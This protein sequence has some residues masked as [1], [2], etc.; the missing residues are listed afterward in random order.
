MEIGKKQQAS[1]SNIQ[2]PWSKYTPG[3][4][5]RHPNIWISERKLRSWLAGHLSC[6]T[7]TQ[8]CG[9]WTHPCSARFQLIQ[10]A[11]TLASS[12][13]STSSDLADFSSHL[14]ARILEVDWWPGRD[15]AKHQQRPPKRCLI[16]IPHPRKKP[17]LIAPPTTETGNT[18]R[19][20]K[21]SLQKSERDSENSNIEYNGVHIHCSTNDDIIY[22]IML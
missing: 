7:F 5:F 20:Q 10:D 6:S 15:A 1:T 13:A 18:W 2:D 19:T 22:I 4:I 3:F 16:I 8:V 11:A 21:E 14:S 17:K 12:F 9:L